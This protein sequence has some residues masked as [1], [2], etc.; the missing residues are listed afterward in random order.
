MLAMLAF[1]FLIC[2]IED[3]TYTDNFS[4]LAKLRP[5]LSGQCDSVAIRK[6]APRLFNTYLVALCTETAAREISCKKVAK[7]SDD[8]EYHIDVYIA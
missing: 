6:K 1:K 8:I 7:V 3:I 2:N 5:D 4:L